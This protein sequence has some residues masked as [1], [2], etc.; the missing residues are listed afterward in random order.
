MA[1]ETLSATP[2]EPETPAIE[3][4]PQAGNEPDPAETPDP[5]LE[6]SETAA[7]EGEEG[8]EAEQLEEIE[9]DGTTYQVPKALKGAF[10]KNADYTQKTQDV[11][12]RNKAL[13]TREAEI[14]ER[15]KATDDE[16][17]ER[18]NL[19]VVRAQLDEFGR[20]DWD[21]YERQDPLAAQTHWRQ[22][23]QLKEAARNLEGSIEGKVNTRTEKAKQ[24][25][26]KRLQDTVEFAR[27]NIPG[28][29]PEMD[30]TLVQ[31][32]ID[33][34]VPVA[35]LRQ[36]MSPVFYTLLHKSYVGHQTLAKPAVK[37]T[38]PQAAPLTV[39]S[40]KSNPTTRKTVAEMSV[41]DHADAIKRSQE[42]RRAS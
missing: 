4:A 5:E 34:G 8:G 2:N 23:Q 12:A 32:A 25:T 31:F 42:K 7:P 26:A 39:V 22:F 20:V 40:A 1:D 13:D 10:M 9:L 36:L 28:W 27:K 18:A 30:N 16:L 6:D 29:Q 38:K 3:T 15:S 41:A 19:T 17:T 37:V 35:T 11:S 33:H 14:E 24:E 21:A